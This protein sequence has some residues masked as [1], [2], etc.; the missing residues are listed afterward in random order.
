MPFCSECGKEIEG[1]DKYCNSCGQAAV[2][3]SGHTNIKLKYLFLLF[4]I[5]LGVLYEIHLTHE[6]ALP[7]DLMLAIPWGIAGFAIGAV[8]DGLKKK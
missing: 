8:L 1:T 2:A 7:I 3:P 6:V 5:A 4:G